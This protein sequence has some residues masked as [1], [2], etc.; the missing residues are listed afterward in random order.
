MTIKRSL[1]ITT[2]FALSTQAFALPIDWHGVLGFDTTI[3][4]GYRKVE[5]T[6]DN[7]GAAGSQEVSLP[8]GGTQ[9][10]N[11]QNYVFRLM[12]NIVVNDSASIKAEFSNGYGR[13]GFIGNDSTQSQKAGASNQL[14]PF[15][16][17]D[18]GDALTVN[19][20][21]AELYSDT[22]TYVIGRHSQHFGLGAVVN[23]G[24]DIW[25][26][27][28]YLRDGLTI[29]V[30]L[31]NFKIEPYWTRVATG[32]SL[33]KGTR[34][35]DYG[36][37]LIYDSVERDLAFGILYN[38]KQTTANSTDYTSDVTGTSQTLANGDVKLTDIY[39]KKSFG[40][41]DI[42]LEVPILSGEMGNLFGSGVTKY[43]AN[44]YILESHYKTSG[45]WSFSFLAGMVSGDDGT[46]NSYDA[47][48]LNPNYQVANLLF[49][50]NMQA[51]GNSSTYSIYDSYINNATY[52]KLGS[53]YQSE[54][55][56]WDIA[57]IWAKADQTAQ[58]G[59][60]SY[61]HLTNKTFSANYSQKDDL[62]LEIDTGF[63][64][65]WNSE[66]T[67]GANVGYLFTGDYFAYTNTATENAVDNSYVLQLRTSINF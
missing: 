18:G 50:Y 16:F 1:L 10:A 17:S 28:F 25:D 59:T 56:K 41:F 31:G 14:Y 46:D 40:N 11:W 2:L 13:G 22:A 54:K 47:M 12:P 62:G 57:G 45:S 32:N 33:S 52:I 66:V 24:E 15:N 21:Y 3:V 65:K 26:R 63:E 34:I 53:T 60:T 19:Q 55:W 9:N 4:D 20:L 58:A 35:K 44:A 5:S 42:G 48:Y 30:K 36:V 29:K 6:V 67:V 51:V 37:S 39:I 27:F 7:S 61:N 49:R 23:S 43:K 8:T 38:K 64:Y